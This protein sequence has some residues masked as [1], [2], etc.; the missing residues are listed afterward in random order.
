MRVLPADTQKINYSRVFA[1]LSG[2]D[3]FH[4]VSLLNKAVREGLIQPCTKNY[5]RIVKVDLSSTIVKRAS[6]SMVYGLKLADILEF[7]IENP[8]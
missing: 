3:L 8:T 2:S 7:E 5:G 6:M 1:Y 4:K